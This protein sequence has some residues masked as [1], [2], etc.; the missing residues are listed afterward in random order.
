MVCVAEE[1]LTYTASLSASLIWI[2]EGVIVAKCQLSN[3]STI[4]WREQANF[5]WDDEVSFVLDQHA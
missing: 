1:L 2:S 4:S 3:F 5:Q